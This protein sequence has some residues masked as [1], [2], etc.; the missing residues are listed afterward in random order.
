MK[1]VLVLLVV[2]SSPVF[3]QEATAPTLTDAQQLTLRT[4]EL[5]SEN[6]QLRMAL[7][8][9]ELARIQVELNDAV[10]N[11]AREGFDLQR[12]NDGVWRYTPKPPKP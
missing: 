11:F 8:Q 6:V 1:R 10:K 4:L 7:L 12:A 2:L 9:V 5:R 3:A